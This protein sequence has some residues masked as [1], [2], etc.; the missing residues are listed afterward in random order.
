MLQAD[1]IQYKTRH[2]EPKIP[3]HGYDG[4]GQLVATCAPDFT[5]IDEDLGWAEPTQQ[6]EETREQEI[7]TAA[8]GLAAIASWIGSSD[9]LTS[10]GLRGLAVAL[11]LGRTNARTGAELA[12]A[13]GVARQ[14]LS[15]Y[16]SELRTVLAPTFR[17]AGLRDNAE[18]QMRRE[19]AVQAHSK[20]DKLTRV[21]IV[22]HRGRTQILIPAK[23]GQLVDSVVARLIDELGPR[24]VWKSPQAWI[25]KMRT[26]AILVRPKSGPRR[27]LRP[28]QHEAQGIVPKVSVSI[29]F[30]GIKGTIRVEREQGFRIFSVSQ[31]AAMLKRYGAD[32][33]KWHSRNAAFDFFRGRVR[34][35][36]QF[37]RANFG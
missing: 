3:G 26:G 12:A 8:D 18:R 15:K 32:P 36:L 2:P 4:A 21:E 37:Q 23:G 29:T 13:F 7:Q 10:A 34:C 20:H 27:K 9:C 14:N 17:A 25:R 35:K 16:T 30:A 33:S 24:S 5:Q 22:S 19:V 6:P 28:Q 11:V 31:S 1:S